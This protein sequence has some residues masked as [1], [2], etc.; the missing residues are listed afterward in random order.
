MPRAIQGIL[1]SFGTREIEVNCNLPAPKQGRDGLLNASNQYTRK[2]H[3]CR[4]LVQIWIKVR[5]H[6]LHSDRS[7]IQA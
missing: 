3:Y 4:C 7:L 2:L 6:E 1:L 5:P